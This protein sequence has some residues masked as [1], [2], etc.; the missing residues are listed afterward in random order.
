M[1]RHITKCIIY[2]ITAR[3]DKIAKLYMHVEYFP[4]FLHRVR[5]YS[6]FLSRIFF[7]DTRY[8]IKRHSFQFQYSTLDI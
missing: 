5:F 1:R 6:S 3:V 8:L 2:A 4:D 7:L